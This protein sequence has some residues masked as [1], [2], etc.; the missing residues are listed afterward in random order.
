MIA[1]KVEQNSIV[2]VSADVIAHFV[3]E[4]KEIHAR[5]IGSLKKQFRS[6]HHALDSGAAPTMFQETMTL[7]P[8]ELKAS[9]LVLVGAG[10]IEALTLERLRRVAATAAK[11]ANKLK[12]VS[13]AIVE[14][15]AE[16]NAADNWSEVGTA[17]AEGAV[18][19]QYKYNKHLTGENKKPS[20]LTSI[21]LI[22]D[23]SRR[24]KELVKGVALANILVEATYIARDLANAPANE[25]YPETL[26]RRALRLGRESK[27]NVTV[28]N[29]R[30]ITRLGMGGVL[31]V[32]K[33][34]DRPARFI[35]MEH[36]KGKKFPT[37]VLV[38]KGVTFDAGGISIK[39]AAGM[40][41]MKMDMHG[42][43]T[44]IATMQAVARLK[45]PLHIVGLVP[46]VE[47][48]LGG[49][50]MKPGDI[51][52]HYNGKTSEVDN[53]DAEGRL[54]LADALSYASHYK[55]EL[56][57]DVATL[58]GH[59]VVGLGTHA[60]GMMGNDQLSMDRLK[61]AGERTYE[62]V[63]QLPMFEEYE[64]QNKSDVAD[65]KNS[66]GRPAGA[67]TAAFFLKQF[68]GNYRWMHLDIAGTGILNEA[69]DYVPKGASGVGV[70][71]LVDFLRNWSK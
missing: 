55:P 56:V 43:A 26:A 49:K 21:K 28:F 13:L 44:V 11:T 67:I 51:I 36:Y 16:W 64:K 4:D 52:V 46:S 63:W 34:S 12:A 71:L 22:S 25:I 31:A 30:R 59:V 40:S 7:F 9:K 50:A 3:A 57:I 47:N 23:D 33:G 1:V 58:T 14:P 24:S 53:T 10:K 42:A 27:L 35:I 61:E 62:R 15:D 8:V 6:L 20:T 37:I 17:L 5:Q 69:L 48:L 39:P 60:T 70:R 38:G 2:R 29:E 45:L 54:I 66:G 32:A 18:L 19:S 65:V 41:E 68:T